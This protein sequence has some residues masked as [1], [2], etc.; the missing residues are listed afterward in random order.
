MNH[1]RNAN[2]KK[3]KKKKKTEK[4][5]TSNFSVGMLTF[6]FF[7]VNVVPPANKSLFSKFS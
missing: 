4:Q 6:L 2:L 1:A 7:D 5:D 3:K